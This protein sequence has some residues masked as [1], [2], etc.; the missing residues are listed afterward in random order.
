[1]TNTNKT[2]VA[3]AT[4]NNFITTIRECDKLFIE[5]AI[6]LERVMN[7][8]LLKSILDGSIHSLINDS[9]S[10]EAIAN[11]AAFSLFYS[12]VAHCKKEWETF[13]NVNKVTALLLRMLCDGK[14]FDQ[15]MTDD[16]MIANTF[17]MFLCKAG[18]K[19]WEKCRE[20]SCF[21]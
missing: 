20:N 2:N 8:D 11:Y 6:T 21:E 7:H 14:P 4:N 18:T 9:G 17:E 1:M 16:K 19:K 12:P 10:R 15:K 5:E 13:E 3:T